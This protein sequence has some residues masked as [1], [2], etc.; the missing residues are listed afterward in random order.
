[1][2]F[3]INSDQKHY[4]KL[5]T[6]C[7]LSTCIQS[8][9]NEGCVTMEFEIY[10]SNLSCALKFDITWLVVS[11]RFNRLTRRHRLCRVT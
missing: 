1:M 7:E 4:M 6:T 9:S 5:S 11:D 8:D 10:K 3:R 2:H